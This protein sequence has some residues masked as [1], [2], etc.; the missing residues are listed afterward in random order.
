M[1]TDAA[2]G[3]GGRFR[4]V[5]RMR[6]TVEGD[7]MAVRRFL[8]G[9]AGRGRPVVSFRLPPSHMVGRYRIGALG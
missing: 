2:P 1:H 5:T 3:L 4:E 9:V 6:L 7:R 8:L